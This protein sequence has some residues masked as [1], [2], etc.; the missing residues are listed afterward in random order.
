MTMILCVACAT[1][2]ASAHGQ[3]AGGQGGMSPAALAKANGGIPPFT[4]ADVDF[5]SGMI[6]HH[7]QAVLMAGWAPSHG[8]RQDVRLLCE[9]IAVAQTDEIA[10][11]QRWLRDR[12]QPVPDAHNVHGHMMPGMDMPMLMPGML[13]DEQLAELDHARGPEFDRLFLTDMIKHHQGAITMV[14]TLLG[15]SGAAE[16][17]IIYRFASDVTADQSTEIERMQKMLAQP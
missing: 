17:D 10:S 15:T 8:A 4:Q 12:K 5:M 9:R 11:M 16:D 14:E 3:S 1:A 2:C 13:T 6:G 7:A